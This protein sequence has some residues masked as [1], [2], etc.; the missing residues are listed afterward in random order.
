MRCYFSTIYIGLGT[1]S[2]AWRDVNT[3]RHDVMRDSQ[4]TGLT[5]HVVKQ[6][7]LQVARRMKTVAKGLLL[8]QF[9]KDCLG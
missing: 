8:G 1:L 7:E 2:D 4:L 9:F 5:N 6:F 3:A